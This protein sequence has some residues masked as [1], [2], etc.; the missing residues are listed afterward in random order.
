MQK[1]NSIWKLNT[2]SK[3]GFTVCFML[4]PRLV[5]LKC[6]QKFMCHLADTDYA[7]KHVQLESDFVH[8]QFCFKSTLTVIYYDNFYLV[9]YS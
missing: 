1:P 4:K 3:N 2:L 6:F 7:G 9:H 8:G 5:S